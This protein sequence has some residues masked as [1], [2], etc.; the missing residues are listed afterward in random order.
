MANVSAGFSR[1][2]RTQKGNNPLTNAFR[3][4]AMTA[5]KTK[6]FIGRSARLLASRVLPKKARLAVAR[7]LAMMVFNC[8][9]FGREPVV[10]TEEEFELKA[11]K[12]KKDRFLRELSGYMQSPEAFRELQAMIR[13][14][15]Q[16]TPARAEGL[17]P[18]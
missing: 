10:W 16:G 12:R 2:A 18:A 4:A 17:A 1:Q 5:K 11:R 9:K 13:E 14:Y 6:T 3:M 15:R 7:K 8:L